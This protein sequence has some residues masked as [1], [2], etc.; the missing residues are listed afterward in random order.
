M[1]V[2]KDYFYQIFTLEESLCRQE[3]FLKRWLKGEKV[4]QMA[5]LDVE[6]LIGQHLC[7]YVLYS[8][9]VCIGILV[10]NGWS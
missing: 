3:I 1:K 6:P 10:E 2:L 5:H 8:F 4:H 9:R 7:R